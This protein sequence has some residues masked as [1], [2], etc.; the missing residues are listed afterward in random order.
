MAPGSVLEGRAGSGTGTSTKSAY[1]ILS[2]PADRDRMKG[3][4]V[5][6]LLHMRMILACSIIVILFPFF[7]ILVMS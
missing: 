1:A 6:G 4:S 2:V 3:C 7:I 5:K